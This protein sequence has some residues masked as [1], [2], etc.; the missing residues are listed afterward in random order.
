MFRVP[1]EL[2]AL[3]EVY[4][5]VRRS[6]QGED[7]IILLGDFNTNDQHLYR[8]GEIPGISPLIKGIWTN[9]EQNRQLD[10]MIIH[11]PS[12]TEYTGQSGVLDI[13]RQWNLSGRQALQVSDHFPIWAEF[14]I[15]ERDSIGRIARRPK[16]L[17]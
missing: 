15:Y 10:N 3:A 8:L 16:Q 12:T 2:D 1:E 9:T 13:I 7:D 4:R 6:S 17:R 14:S 5:V 11:R